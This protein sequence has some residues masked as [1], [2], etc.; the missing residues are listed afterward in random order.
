MTIKAYTPVGLEWLMQNANIYFFLSI[1]R[2]K[3]DNCCAWAIVKARF[4]HQTKIKAEKIIGWVH[5]LSK[6]LLFCLSTKSGREYVK[7]HSINVLQ[8]PSEV[9]KMNRGT[10]VMNYKP[11]F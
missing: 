3:K 9:A 8:I 4:G 6:R 7:G 10:S 2:F 1:F 11:K 5:F